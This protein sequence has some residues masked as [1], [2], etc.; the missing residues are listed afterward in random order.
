MIHDW[1]LAETNQS[2]LRGR[3]TDVAVLPVGAIEPHNLHLPEGQDFFHTRYVA[4]KSCELAFEQGAAVLCLP[5]IP[6]GVD[7]NLQDFPLAV[8]VSQDTLNRLVTDIVRSLHHYR[9]HKIVLVNGH[10]GNDF[11]PLIRQ[12]QCDLPV[13]LFLCNWW[14]VGMDRYHEIFDEEDDHAG[15]LET[16]VALA[17]YPELVEMEKARPGRP[18]AFQFEALRNGWVSTSRRFGRLNRECGVG[19]PRKASAEKGRAYLDLVCS[20]L[21]RFLVELARA[22]LTGEF[23]HL[24]KSEPL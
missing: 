24:A 19:D 7:C 6:Y 10:G 22:P 15:E 20:R 8:H 5:A 11:T 12:L 4:R 13:H 2:R 1:D 23:P 18:A 9:I 21:S 3:N 14:K 17:L 16:S